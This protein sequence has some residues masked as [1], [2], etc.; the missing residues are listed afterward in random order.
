MYSLRA[1]AV[2]VVCARV[3]SSRAKM[4][5]FAACDEMELLLFPHEILL[6]IV[7]FTQPVQRNGLIMR[8]EACARVCDALREAVEMHCAGRLCVSQAVD[9]WAA[10]HL[11]KQHRLRE[12]EFSDEGELELEE[13]DQELS[14]EGSQPEALDEEHEES[15]D[16][17]E[18]DA[19]RS[20]GE[21]SEAD[22]HDDE[23]DWSNDDQH[24]DEDEDTGE[25]SEEEDGNEYEDTGEYS[26]EEDGNEY[27]DTG[28]Y[29]DDDGSEY[30]DKQPDESEEEST[31][32]EESS[33][34]DEYEAERQQWL[35]E[36]QEEA[37][38]KRDEA[39]DEEN[40]RRLHGHYQVLLRPFLALAM[41]RLER[42]ETQY[43]AASMDNVGRAT[44]ALSM[45][46]DA[47]VTPVAAVLEEI[48]QLEARFTC[49]GGRTKEDQ[50]R[51]SDLTDMDDQGSFSLLNQEC[52]DARHVA[53]QEN[54]LE[55]W[56]ATPDGG[57]RLVAFETALDDDWRL[58]LMEWEETKQVPTSIASHGA[59]AWLE[60]RM[61]GP[62]LEG[63]LLVGP[64][65]LHW[66]ND[67][68]DPAL[69]PTPTCRIS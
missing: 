67:G 7:S 26:E 55:C 49:Q 45:T 38:R 11:T 62:P 18:Y 10:K 33:D 42:L 58:F 21:T 19:S 27:E 16:E 57:F 22:I 6:S 17:S 15:A 14:N 66:Q 56:E 8:P 28:E 9:V 35:Y 54:V 37:R 25:Y 2:G 61:V 13:D 5:D 36:A 51:V 59:N 53:Q 23:L 20:V 64:L 43:C 30:E 47:M 50:Q 52:L 3:C 31:M 4:E 12:L 60:R 48:R 69:D 63:R 68:V 29:S 44:L 65:P 46:R 40:L 34:T 41:K 24:R 1:C 32:L 39:R